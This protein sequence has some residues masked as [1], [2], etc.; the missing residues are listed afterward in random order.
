MD[1]EFFISG[2]RSYFSVGFG[3]K[4]YMV[5]FNIPNINYAFV[6][7]SFKCGRVHSMSRLRKFFHKKDFCNLN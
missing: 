7:P 2:S 3:S 5:F 6:F 4:S 1:P